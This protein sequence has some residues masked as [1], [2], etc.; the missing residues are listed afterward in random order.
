MFADSFAIHFLLQTA[1]K[2]KNKVKRKA[3]VQHRHR[4]R[5]IHNTFSEIYRCM[6]YFDMDFIFIIC[7][8]RMSSVLL[9]I[10][11]NRI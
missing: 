9:K 8:R 7:I 3:R 4:E 10:K 1:S 11:T 6:E 2:M 5:D